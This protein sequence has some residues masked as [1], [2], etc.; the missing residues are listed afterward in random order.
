MDITYVPVLGFCC[1]SR[2]IT[3][4]YMISCDRIWKGGGLQFPR[5]KSLQL[6]LTR[7]RRAYSVKMCLILLKQRDDLHNF[8]QS[9]A[10]KQIIAF[11]RSSDSKNTYC[12]C[13]QDRDKLQCCD[14]Q[15]KLSRFYICMTSLNIYI[16]IL[17][18]SNQIPKQC[19]IYEHEYKRVSYLVS[20][21]TKC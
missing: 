17:L 20:F 1:G 11:F 2:N 3:S 16:T 9:W 15:K 21:N 5:E 8:H 19:F 12:M 14:H 6:K 18:W 10:V 13:F 7:Q 4:H